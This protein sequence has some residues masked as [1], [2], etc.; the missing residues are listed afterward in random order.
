MS[1]TPEA[2]TTARE[3]AKDTPLE[4]ATTLRGIYLNKSEFPNWV[5]EPDRWN[6]TGSD[7]EKPHKFDDT[8]VVYD[9][10]SDLNQVKELV[11][12][13]EPVNIE[14]TRN[15]KND[16]LET[17]FG[18]RVGAYSKSTSSELYPNIGI[19]CHARVTNEEKTEEKNVHVMNLIGYAFDST[20][21]PD[22]QYFLKTYGGGASDLNTLSSENKDNFK[23]EL[24]QRYRKI[25]LKACY[26]C[27]LKS[28]KNL[29]YYGV[30]SGFFSKLLPNEY[31]MASG[32][33]YQ[34]IFAP[35][36]GID[37]NDAGDSPE[38]ST[39]ID[40][41]DLT[42]PI[43][44]CIKYGIKVQN[45][46]N[47]T[48]QSPDKKIPDVLFNS[49]SSPNDTL[50]INAWDPWS[51]IGNGNAADTSLD[52]HWGRNSNMSVLGWSITNSKLLPDIVGGATT[53]TS[54][55]LKMS[56]ILAKIEAK[57]AGSSGA[58]PPM[59]SDPIVT[60]KVA[61]F[62]MTF[63]N[64]KGDNGGLSG[65]DQCRKIVN[66]VKCLMA[67]GY[68]HIGLT[69][70]ANQEQTNKIWK[71]YNYPTATGFDDKTEKT[72]LQTGIDGNGQAKTI[73]I[74]NKQ[75]L[76]GDKYEDIK[77]LIQTT[78]IDDLTSNSSD[79]NSNFKKA[80]RI[81]PFSTM[82]KSG[83]TIEV[84]LSSSGDIEGCIAAAKEFLKLD[85]SII[86]G[87]CNQDIETLTNS[88]KDSFKKDYTLVD[89]GKFPFA[90]G[91]G[92]GGK[93]NLPILFRTYLGQYFEFLTSVWDPEVQKIVTSCSPDPKSADS[94]TSLSRPAPATPPASE[95]PKKPFADVLTTLESQISYEHDQDTL[96]D[97]LGDGNL[98]YP[99]RSL[100]EVSSEHNVKNEKNL[101][102]AAPPIDVM[103]KEFENATDE[104]DKNFYLG[105]CRSIQAA[106]DLEMSG[107]PTDASTD[108]AK[109]RAKL[110]L[111]LR[112]NSL[113]LKVPAR[114]DYAEM[115]LGVVSGPPDTLDKLMNFSLQDTIE[116]YS[117][118]GGAGN[119][120]FKALNISENP[121]MSWTFECNNTNHNINDVDKRFTKGIDSTLNNACY[122][123]TAL[124][125]L[126]CNEDFLQL[127]I[128]GN[129]Q[130]KFLDNIKNNLSVSECSVKKVGS[131]MND[132][133]KTQDLFK[134][135]KDILDKLITFFKQYLNNKDNTAIYGSIKQ[136]LNI[137]TKE[138]SQ[139]D[140]LEVI[141]KIL[142][143]L[144]CCSNLYTEKF[145]NNIKVDISTTRTIPSY[146]SSAEYRKTQ[147]IPSNYLLLENELALNFI[148]TGSYTEPED[149]DTLSI[150]NV[151]TLLDD[152]LKP[153]TKQAV[154]PE[155]LLSSDNSKLYNDAKSLTSSKSFIGLFKQICAMS[156]NLDIT[157]NYSGLITTL[158]SFKKTD[159]E[160]K[161]IADYNKGKF[162]N[163][164]LDSIKT[165][166]DSNIGK[167]DADNIIKICKDTISPANKDITYVMSS[168]TEPSGIDQTTEIKINNVN[169][170]LIIRI[171]RTFNG[172][173]DNSKINPD[174]VIQ[175]NKSKYILQGYSV[176]LGSDITGGAHYIFVK[177]DPVTGEEKLI[178][179][180]GN[181]NDI[182]SQTN[183]NKQKGVFGLIYKRADE[184]GQAGGGRF[185]PM[186]NT[187]TNH[188]A[189]KSKHNSSFKASSSSKSKGKGHNRSHTQRVK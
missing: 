173:K 5:L 135:N 172:I 188:T 158:N 9:N 44:F 156:S 4:N 147:P 16:D 155:D 8:I 30:G 181:L 2:T 167:F 160:Y 73:G 67:K 178:L 169:K 45:L 164:Y 59:G 146:G 104:G 117:Q 90:I 14:M 10:D 51:I 102:S 49:K 122:F 70:S 119:A 151:Q 17:N 18:W 3:K 50:Y 53:E 130:D 41:T 108:L 22:Y 98:I 27:K 24:I 166:I 144:D 176:H 128:Q 85:N 15:Y 180:D 110:L 29:W 39:T 65:Y 99:S 107:I 36:F 161:N 163:T 126:L 132:D 60:G 123:N 152:Y 154:I 139:Q 71:E 55:I 121:E 33:F 97:L 31:N 145:I 177:C 114:W 25:W 120:E 40:P 133:E 81:I 56:D 1:S 141:T 150:V 11:E 111:N 88:N 115:K 138:D 189:Y 137:E 6:N 86:L 58:S 105:A 170:Y 47:E 187:I 101:N 109:M 100:G 162:N 140:S 159:N 129:C 68:K 79:E 21:Q 54:K 61:Q 52:G 12:K 112:K 168:L 13:R 185:K 75:E 171:Q 20:E 76:K 116:Y 131:E 82:E 149:F 93:A 42:I 38:K 28:L 37:P 183:D 23:K 136:L 143:A 124:Q 57:D 103:I 83:G 157:P 84:K 46:Q 91:G 34:E 184:L 69:Y 7:L 72:I 174:K 78:Y 92:V 48:T 179:N 142:I 32:K 134:S 153:K 148:N 26:I 125:L 66:A 64:I 118:D 95:T 77:P 96:L 175:V 87:W 182:N 35:A 113:L 127:M 43:N 74:R 63:K 106:Y 80:F 62:F 94:P 165:F 19:Y 89:A 186:H